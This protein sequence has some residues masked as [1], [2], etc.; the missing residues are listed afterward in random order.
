MFLMLNNIDQKNKQALDI[1]L[2][3]TPTHM[4]GSNPRHFNRCAPLRSNLKSL[5]RQEDGE[6]T[7]HHSGLRNTFRYLRGSF[8]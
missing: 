6:A 3:A 4:P 2:R 1:Y 7:E 5:L 8:D